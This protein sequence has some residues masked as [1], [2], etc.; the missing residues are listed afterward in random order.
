MFLFRRHLDTA[1][2]D[3]LPPMTSQG[4]SQDCEYGVFLFWTNLEPVFR[5]VL[6]VLIKILK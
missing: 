5:D 6:R 3:V 1:F 2:G 4:F